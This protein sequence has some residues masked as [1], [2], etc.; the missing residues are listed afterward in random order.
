MEIRDQIIRDLRALGVREGDTVLMH[1]SMKSLGT[2]RPPEYVLDAVQAA[3]GDSGTL[4]LPALSYATVNRENPFWDYYGTP[5]CV[6]LLPETFRHL[7]GVLRSVS[8]TH[9]VCA[10]GAGAEALVA[11]QEEDDTPIGPHSPYRRL[12]E[13]GGKI[14]MLG[15]GMGP[16]TF[17]HGVEEVAPAPYV[18][19]PEP[20]LYH[21]TDA[22][23]RKFDK[24]VYRHGN[25][26]FGAQ[27]YARAEPLLGAGE[28][29]R[30]RVLAAD[31]YLV[32]AA[33]LMRV[34]VETMRREPYYFLELHPGVRV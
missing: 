7:P 12:P 17:M 6:G 2:D 23:G 30:G 3:V 14:L 32:D 13:L 11:G 20:W 8:P 25:S 34:G 1:S 21:M 29:S 10:R 22:Q 24:L 19:L 9:S 33:A 31:A 28:I 27:R 18:F 15:C 5:A 26:R 16:M 4:A